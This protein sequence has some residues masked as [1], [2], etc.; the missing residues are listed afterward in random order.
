MTETESRDAPLVYSVEDA[1]R[2]LRLSRAT[3]YAMAKNGSIPTVRFG[4][5]V[6]VPRKALEALLERSQL[7]V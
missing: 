1:G 7:A 6:R 4:R 5:S 3:A 2:L